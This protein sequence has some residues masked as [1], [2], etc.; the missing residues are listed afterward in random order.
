MAT[1]NHPVPFFDDSYMVNSE[2]M[3]PYVG[4]RERA[5]EASAKKGCPSAAEAGS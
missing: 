5:S 4:E 3:G 2:S 1:L